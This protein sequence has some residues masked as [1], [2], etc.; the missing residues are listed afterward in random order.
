MTVRS[1]Y[2]G[3]LLAT[4]VLMTMA[5]LVS[6]GWAREGP[7]YKSSLTAQMTRK[8][9]R[10]TAN[11]VFGWCEI[12]RNIHI[13]VENLDPFT[14]TVVGLVHG[15]GQGVVR[16]GWGLWEMVTFPIPIPSEYRNLVQPEFVWQDLFE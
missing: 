13:E 2:R 10:G 8:L 1:G 4:M 16:T 15:T 9:V 7:Y 5:F 12:P 11:V 14:G 6:E 3:K